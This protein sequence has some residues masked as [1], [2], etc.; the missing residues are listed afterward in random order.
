MT[1]AE[2]EF[3]SKQVHSA[4]RFYQKN[5]Q[6]DPKSDIIILNGGR[7]SC[8]PGYHIN[9]ENF[10]YF[11][12][13]FVASGQG[14]L[15][16]NGTKHSL[17]PGTIFTY[18]PGI[19]HTIE[20]AGKVP[21]VKYFVNFS[22]PNAEELLTSRNI[23]A[24]VMHTSTPDSILGTFEEL[25]EY[26]LHQSPY[27]KPICRHLLEVLS[28][29]YAESSVSQE[30]R[31]SAAYRTYIRCRQTINAHY[32]SINTVDELA[33]L[34]HTDA[35]YLCRLFGRFDHQSPYKYLMRLKMNY[36]ADLL[37][38]SGQPVKEVALIMGYEDPYHFSRAF[39]NYMGLSPKKY[40]ENY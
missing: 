7:E 18:G 37:L 26:G 6:K 11:S 12:L 2:P 29:K 39:R 3:F 31:G 30:A 17:T 20:N 21:L 40:C 8:Q 28:L 23:L 27:S 5:E 15:T 22:G 16:L 35:S 4:K 33:D 38:A 24:V 25:T 14:N 19:A 13:E 36:A 9:R 32:L 1:A 10:P 34:S